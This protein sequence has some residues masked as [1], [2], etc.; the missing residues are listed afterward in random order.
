MLFTILD[1][2]VLANS[3]CSLALSRSGMYE[4]ERVAN[5]AQHGTAFHCTAGHDIAGHRTPLNF[6][7]ELTKLS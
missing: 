2:L 1:M 4:R 6:A 3:V 5:M 7:A